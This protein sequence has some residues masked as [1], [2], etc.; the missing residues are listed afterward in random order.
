MRDLV[1]ARAAAADIRA[2]PSSHG[3][4]LLLGGTGPWQQVVDLAIWMTV[5][6]FGQD[7]WE[8]GNGG[9]ALRN[10]RKARGITFRRLLSSP[11]PI[12]YCVN[13]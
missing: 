7:T 5:D 8:I 4:E 13:E 11:Y 2:V 3:L 12:R 1:H 10:C 6:D 9:D